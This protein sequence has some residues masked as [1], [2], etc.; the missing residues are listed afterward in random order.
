MSKGIVLMVTLSLL[1]ADSLSVVAQSQGS[2]FAVFQDKEGNSVYRMG[3]VGPLRWVRVSR[4][5]RE[6]TQLTV[7]ND[8]SFL[9]LAASKMVRFSTNDSPETV[10]ENVT[11]FCYNRQTNFIFAIVRVS[12]GGYSLAVLG[13][14]DFSVKPIASHP[15]LDFTS[16]VTSQ[17]DRLVIRA[18]DNRIYAA[19]LT[20]L[21]FAPV[22]VGDDPLLDC[23]GQ[24][25]AFLDRQS[26]N[27][28]ILD[29]STGRVKEL[30]TGRVGVM[31]WVGNDMIAYSYAWKSLFMIEPVMRMALI[32]VDSGARKQ[33]PNDDMSPQSIDWAN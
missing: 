4:P 16:T 3:V 21:V 20:D 33:L 10:A 8:K 1:L 18:A 27:I 26:R 32:N 14:P 15:P 23:N 19:S 2:I 7:L 24:R 13:W 28:R 17:G 25:L 6:L 29:V 5:L 9:G 11:S 30:R 31:T 22:G 12:S